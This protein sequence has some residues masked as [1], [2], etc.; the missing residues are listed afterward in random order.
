MVVEEL[1][2]IL[3]NVVN[4]DC[5]WVIVEE[6]VNI[7]GIVVNI[8]CDWVVVYGVFEKTVETDNINGLG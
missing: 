1:D 6:L 4:I 7:L 3:G 2:N 8:D 5:D